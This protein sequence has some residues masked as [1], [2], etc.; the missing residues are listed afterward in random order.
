MQLTKIPQ[1]INC[2]KIYQFSKKDLVFNHISTHSS[3]IKKSSIFVIQNNLKINHNFILEAIKK[4][5]VGIITSK[6]LKNFKVNQY[7]VEDIDSSLR[8][9]LYKLYP[10]KP[11]YHTTQCQGILSLIW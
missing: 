8:I 1:Y 3:H 4:G 2:K 5:A 6:Y 7:N 10:N 9:L 11:P